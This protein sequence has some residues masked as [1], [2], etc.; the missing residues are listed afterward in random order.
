MK[1]NLRILSI[2]ALVVAIPSLIITDWYDKDYG[3]MVMFAFLTVGLVL[4]TKAF[5]KW[6]LG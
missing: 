5:R 4:E 3:L 1:K 6:E 2:A